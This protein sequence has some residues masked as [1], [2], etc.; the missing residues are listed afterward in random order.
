VVS[1]TVQCSAAGR[2]VKP[3]MRA[4]GFLRDFPHAL[5]LFRTETPSP[6]ALRVDT[7]ALHTADLSPV[8]RESHPTAHHRPSTQ[9]S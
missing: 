9:N 4:A 6:A 7:Q 1:L 2:C 3:R 5:R 8:I